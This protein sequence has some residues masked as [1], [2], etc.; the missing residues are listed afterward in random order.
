VALRGVVE[1]LSDLR[2]R[3]SKFKT[4]SQPLTFSKAVTEFKNP[5]RC[6]VLIALTNSVEF[7]NAK[8]VKTIKL[9]VMN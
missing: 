7:R 4:G 6:G 2:D 5:T 8:D 9:R 1:N 3:G